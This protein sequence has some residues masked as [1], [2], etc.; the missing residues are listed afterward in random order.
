MI[1]SLKFENS[2]F[3]GRPLAGLHETPPVTTLLLL[4]WVS[5][6]P[7]PRMG[8]QRRHLSPAALPKCSATPGHNAHRPPGRTDLGDSTRA[9]HARAQEN[10]RAAASNQ[11]FYFSLNTSRN[12]KE[13]GLHGC[14][15]Y[16]AKNDWS[17]VHA[18]GKG[19]SSTSLCSFREW[20]QA[21]SQMN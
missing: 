19:L 7:A 3:C 4:F 15:F 2:K 6:P 17:Y 12:S 1:P 18:R 21:S 5:E 9:F 20:N 13:T 10:T 8:P 14:S 16:R 11:G